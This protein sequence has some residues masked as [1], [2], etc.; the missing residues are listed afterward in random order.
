M[1]NPCQVAVIGAGPYGLSVTAHLCAAGIEARVFGRPMEFWTRYMPAGM[2]LRSEKVASNLSDPGNKLGLDAYFTSEGIDLPSD[3]VPVEMFNAYGRWFQEK[4]VPT[5]D[6]RNVSRV[7]AGPDGF[8]LT[9]EDGEQVDADRVVVAAGIAPF[10]YRPPQFSDLPP[11]LASHSSNHN[12]L[13]EFDGKRVI[14][15]GAGQ[16]GFE[17]AALLSEAG[18]EV[19]VIL[20]APSVR[21]LRRRALPGYMDRI[22]RHLFPTHGVGGRR[23]A[24]IIARPDLLRLLP[25]DMRMKI[26]RKAM[27]P[28]VSSWVEPRVGRVRVSAGRTI[29]SA[30]RSAS[31]VS[32]ALD[33]GSQR[34]A[35][36]I[37]LGTGYHVDISRYD[38]IAPELLRSI[39]RTNG[40]PELSAGCESS[41]PGLFFI[42]A[43][44][45]YNFGPL[46]RFVVGSQFCARTVTKAVVAS[47]NARAKKVVPAAAVVR[48][49]EN[50]NGNDGPGGA[51]VIGGEHSALGL[52]RSLGRNH[53]PV[54][55]LVD[56]YKLAAA[57][58]YC[59]RSFPWLNT[60]DEKQV[61]YLLELCRK[62]GLEGWMLFPSGDERVAMIARNHELLSQYFRLTT[63]DWETVRWAYDKRLTYQMAEQLGLGYPW[64]FH[65]HTREELGDLQHP[66]PLIVKPAF[67]HGVNTLTYQKAWAAKDKDELLRLYDKAVKLVDPSAVM[68]QELIPGGGQNQFSYGALCSEGRPIASLVAQRT[69]QYPVDFGRT[70]CFVQTVDMPAV[71]TAATRFLEAIRYTG[72]VEVEFKYDVREEKYKLLDVN[73][74]AW[75]WHC[76]GRSA[77]VDFPF[78]LWRLMS[79]DVPD[80]LKGRPG[81]SWLHSRMDV[82]AGISEILHGRIS[83]PDY[84]RSV[85]QAKEFAVLASDDLMPAFCASAISLTHRVLRTGARMSRGS[86]SPGGRGIKSGTW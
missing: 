10:A 9:L 57:S 83:V 48:H 39:R 60:V 13:S 38:F 24:H 67:K 82:R 56:D 6:P 59:L 50:S 52:V 74:R 85:L 81:V 61:D 79:G 12:D 66:F 41:V 45:A 75:T 31:G 80:R 46:L 54:W 77:G 1:S 3:R 26:D 21:W 49:R 11:E 25:P 33:D 16:S 7:E 76:L 2:L 18:A 19:E 63:P 35:D 72:I 15:I 22:A 14:V 86:A 29:A 8:H 78:L 36:H 20:R 28:A 43:S 23:T 44:C 32:L 40:Y 30:Q 42:G 84:I 62:H 69:R 47:C 55:A 73:A 58:R 37:L 65:P 71:E 4:A 17:S 34:Q 51:L 27:R 5:S 53:I 68:I 70:S 64:T